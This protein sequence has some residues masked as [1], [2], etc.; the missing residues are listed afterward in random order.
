MT[1]TEPARSY[2][3]EAILRAR[4]ENVAIYESGSC[5]ARIRATL[6]EIPRVQ[7]MNRELVHAKRPELDKQKNIDSYKIPRDG[8]G[9]VKA[10]V[11]GQDRG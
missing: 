1:T 4:K 9:L 6:E 3:V 2:A 8:E 5:N 11:P 10:A 7:A